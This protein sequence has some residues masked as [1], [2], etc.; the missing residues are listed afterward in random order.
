MCGAKNRSFKTAILAS[1]LGAI[2]AAAPAHADTDTTTSTAAIL[3]R[4]EFIKIDDLNFGTMYA[5]TTA[6]TVTLAPNGTRTKTG[7]VTLHGTSHKVA[8]FAG[9]GTYN[10]RVSVSLGSN[11]IFITGPG[12]AMRVRTFV[13]GSTP[14]AVLTTNPQVFRIASTNGLFQFPVGATLEVAA[15]QPAGTYTGNWNITLNY[16]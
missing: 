4:L 9:W 8:E 2:L 1:A 13:I 5:G 10:Q 16:Q 15:N 14:T 3:R 7:G 12:P 11:S 6:G